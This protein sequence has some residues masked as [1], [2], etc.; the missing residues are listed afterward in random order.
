MMEMRNRDP[1]TTP[2]MIV[3]F[4]ESCDCQVSCDMP[5]YGSLIWLESGDDFNNSKVV[6]V[7]E[8]EVFGALEDVVVDGI[9][10]VE[11]EYLF[12]FNLSYIVIIHKRKTILVLHTVLT[13]FH[14]TEAGTLRWRI[15]IPRSNQQNVATTE[16]RHHINTRRSMQCSYFIWVNHVTLIYS[17]SVT[18]CMKIPNHNNILKKAGGRKQKD[19]QG[20]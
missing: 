17:F 11:S 7:E 4:C 1:R 16:N 10:D 12:I 5:G 14:I 15:G 8:E 18:A 19:N 13:K 3:F 9:F 2:T 20:H 6:V